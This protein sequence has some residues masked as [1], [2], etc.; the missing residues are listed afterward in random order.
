MLLI[1]GVV[2]EIEATGNGG[3]PFQTPM[4]DLHLKQSILGGKAKNTKE[5]A[6]K[7]ALLL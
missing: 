6:R 1:S 5:V 3:G 7:G 2:K 4:Q